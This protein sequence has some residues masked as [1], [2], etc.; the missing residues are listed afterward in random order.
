M[1][2]I[3]DIVSA[4]E[5]AIEKLLAAIIQQQL[6]VFCGAGI[7]MAPPSCL[8]AA[9]KLT[10]QCVAAY[11]LLGLPVIPLAFRTDL[12]TLTGYLF[13]RGHQDLFVKRIV[14]WGPFRRNPNASHRAIADLLSTSALRFGLTTNFDDLVEQSAQELG[15]EN[16]LPAFDS[17]DANIQNAHAPFIKLHGS[18]TDRDRTLWCRSQIATP[19]EVSPANQE[20]RDRILSITG[21]LGANLAEKSLLFVGFWT[22]WSY[23]NEVLEQAVKAYH[24]ALVVLVDPSPEEVLKSKAPKLWQWAEKSTKFIHVPLRAEKF[25]P[26]FRDA[27]SKNLL[28]RIL[29]EAEPGFIAQTQLKEIPP[30]DFESCTSEDLF[31]LRQDAFCTPSSR[32]PRFREPDGSTDA[33][34]RTHLLLRKGG[35]IL[36]GSIYRNKNGMKI[37]IVNGRTKQLSQVKSEFENSPP[38]GGPSEDLVICAGATDDGGAPA[39]IKKAGAQ[40]TIVRPASTAEWMTL[41]EALIRKVV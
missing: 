1:L 7:S 40:S 8:P 20:I 31:S 16:F 11:N 12:E 36:E 21:Y 17:A 18:V 27:F 4:E 6:V 13:A 33:F 41:D 32:I 25:L 28:T 35:A 38:R 26:A 37:R 2:A 14:N 24:L 30:I 3:G 39:N 23:L 15:E 34:G 22:D 29:K 19:G 5:E 9:A 10:E